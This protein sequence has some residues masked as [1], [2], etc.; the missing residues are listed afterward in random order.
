MKTFTGRRY[1]A[2]GRELLDVHQDRGLAG[3]VD[4]Q[5]LRVGHLH[6][7]GGRQAVAHGAQAAGGHPAVR[8]LELEE[9]RGPHLV[10][11]DLGGDVGI[12]VL[13]QLI[14][15]LDRVLRLD[16]LALLT[17]A[18]AIARPP[19]LDLGPPGLQRLL[20]QLALLRL[21]QLEDGAQRLAGVGDDRQVDHDVL[22]DRGGVD[23][24]V[25][26][27]GVGRELVQPPGHA[28]VEA[29]ADVQH[30]VAVVHRQIGFVGSVHAQHA[31]ELRLARRERRPGPSACW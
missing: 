10:L 28:V 24:D 29:R 9:L 14:E 13:G 30:D 15:P 23:V 1:C 16:D 19:L 18:Q 31:E 6:T 4:H 17:E 2:S 27:L 8:L 25:D 11:A 7:H 22:V 26:L 20:V 12:A 3:D 5:A 21:P